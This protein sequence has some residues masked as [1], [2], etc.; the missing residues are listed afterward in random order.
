MVGFAQ[1]KL[2]E[3]GKIGRGVLG[4]LAAQPLGHKEQVLGETGVRQ[5]IGKL[6]KAGGGFLGT[7]S[8]P[9]VAWRPGSTEG[10]KSHR[11]LLHPQSCLW[12]VRGEPDTNPSRVRCKLFR[13]LQG[14]QLSASPRASGIPGTPIL[15]VFCSITWAC[16]NAGF[17]SNLLRTF[18]L[19]RRH[20]FCLQGAHVALVD[21]QLSKDTRAVA[22][23][24]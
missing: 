8:D 22:Q 6:V 11:M 15:G 24:L 4:R 16:S 1:S 18:S 7:M 23:L 13:S 21:R 10:M 19:C 9:T 12:L 20:G 2:N 3:G 14:A 5:P 17:T